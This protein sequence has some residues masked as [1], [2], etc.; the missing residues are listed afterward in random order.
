MLCG[1]VALLCALRRYADILQ[2]GVGRGGICDDYAATGGGPEDNPDTLV[3]IYATKDNY[4]EDM[5]ECHAML[6][7]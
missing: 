7:V 3:L 1:I 4:E 6:N 5:K 2:T